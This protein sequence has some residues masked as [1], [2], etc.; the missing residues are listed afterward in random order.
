M[1][2]HEHHQ[3]HETPEERLSRLE[4]EHAARERDYEDKLREVEQVRAAFFMAVD[5][6]ERQL[7]Q[8]ELIDKA[9]E[10]ERF[11]HYL[12]GTADAVWKARAA[13]G[14]AVDP[15]AAALPQPADFGAL[16]AE[17]R[18][19][20]LS[21]MSPNSLLSLRAASKT[22]Q[23]MVDA[24]VM[25]LLAES[26]FVVN[27]G[28][29]VGR[30]VDSGLYVDGAQVLADW[31]RGEIRLAAAPP[32]WNRLDAMPA[33]GMQAVARELLYA[34]IEAQN[35]VWP[36]DDEDEKAVSNDL[37]RQLNPTVHDYLQRLVAAQRIERIDNQPVD[38]Q[39]LAKHLF[40]LS[41]RLM[42]GT[43]RRRA[44]PQQN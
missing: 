15:A 12:F 29:E 38:T 3:E 35:D 31:S 14:Q 26:R 19:E 44:A 37:V 28:D 21:L 6:T 39:E 5:A 7:R 11:A 30:Q 22:T 16:P 1:P 25:K 20:V 40:W 43:F 34:V 4:T 2:D 18:I 9:Q 42:V 23:A 36:L 24:H 27:R 13:L 33:Q 10:L 41:Q 32:D 17:T 8:R